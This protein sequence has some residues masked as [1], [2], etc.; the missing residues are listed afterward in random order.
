M[1]ERPIAAETRIDRRSDRV[2]R[3]RARALRR[4]SLVAV[5][6]RRRLGL[7]RRRCG[8]G[9]RVPVRCRKSGSGP[10]KDFSSVIRRLSI[11]GPAFRRLSAPSSWPS[12]CVCSRHPLEPFSKMYAIDWTSLITRTHRNCSACAGCP[13]TAPRAKTSKLLPSVSGTVWALGLTS[14][15]T[16]IS[17]EMVAEC[18]ADVP[19]A[20][21]AGCSRLP[22]ASSTGSTRAPPRSCA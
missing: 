2:A 13:H 12:L 6:D 5:R 8:A 9:A 18:A 21:A 4:A 20:A 10:L 22:S 3:R 7:A 14:L 16:D 19:G 1:T 15:F 11:R 17:S